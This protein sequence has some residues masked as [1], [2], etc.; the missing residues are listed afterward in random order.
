M[1]K[2]DVNVIAFKLPGFVDGTNLD[3]KLP[4]THTM[5][6]M[7]HAFY[8][9]TR[10]PIPSQGVK[11]YLY[12]RT[13]GKYIKWATTLQKVYTNLKQRYSPEQLLDMAAEN[14]N[15]L[16]TFY[17]TTVKRGRAER[18]KW[19]ETGIQTDDDL[20]S[21][22]FND[23]FQN[24]VVAPHQATNTEAAME[25]FSEFKLK[26]QS[27]GYT[28]DVNEL[29]TMSYKLGLNLSVWAKGTDEDD[30]SGEEDA[31]PATVA[32][33]LRGAASVA[34]SAAASGYRLPADSDF[35]WGNAV[36][37][38]PGN[39]G[40][41]ASAS[42]AAAADD[43]DA[44]SAVPDE[45]EVDDNCI[46]IFLKIDSLPIV[47]WSADPLDTI[48]DLKDYAVARLPHVI[49]DADVTVD[50]TGMVLHPD[51]ITV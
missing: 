4:K 39:Q 21:F 13:C 15:V 14:E 51:N 30:D 7:K 27:M 29:D 12:L 8:T 37:P 1:S 26:L 23:D 16:L 5:E 50:A 10:T 36:G 45:P 32:A 42:A 44:S 9:R 18:R 35:Y 34:A 40:E 43:D 6:E 28:V 46:E 3:M 19:V 20:E 25:L 31:P 24:T 41:T 11:T 48:L 17:L 22:T 38:R 49:M 2:L 33:H 47:S